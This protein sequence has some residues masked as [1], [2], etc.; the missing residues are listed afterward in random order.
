MV[1]FIVFSCACKPGYVRTDSTKYLWDF[2]CQKC[3]DIGSSLTP[4]RDQTSCF[5]CDTSD[6]G[7]KEISPSGE[8]VCKEGYRTIEFDTLGFPITDSSNSRVIKC[9]Q[10]PA[11]EYQGPALTSI[12]ECVACP[13]P[14]MVYDARS[15]C[16]C[17]DDY[18][19]AGDGCISKI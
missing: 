2:E 1:I 11:N 5:I 9:E 19:R 15:Q 14:V 13:D 10:C 16:T 4:N 8:C 18:L 6:P 12:W 17:P 3:Q 7:F